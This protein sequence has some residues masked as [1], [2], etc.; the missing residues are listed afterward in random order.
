MVLKFDSSGT[1]VYSTFLGGSANDQ[2][3]PIVV[4]PD[5]TVYVAGYTQSSDFPVTPGAYQTAYGGG[6]DGFLARISADGSQLLYSTYLGGTGDEAVT[7]LLLNTDGSLW[8][9]GVASSAGLTPS[10]NAFQKAPRGV[11][12]SFIAKAQFSPAGVLQLPYLT[13]IGGSQ[14][15]Q[16]NGPGEGWPS[17]LAV[18]AAGNVYYAGTTQSSDFPVTANAYEQPF[19]L[20]H[21]CVNDALPISTGVVTKL[22]PDLS[23]M[24]YSTYFGGKTEDQIGFPY[25]NQGI[26]TIRLDSTGNIWLYGYTAESDLPTTS[27]ALS[28][29]LNTTGNANG[30]DAFLGEL[31]PDGTKLIYGTYIG[32][33]GLDSASSMVFDASGNIWLSGVT[34]STDFPVTANALQAQNSAGVNDLTVTQ[35]SPD[36]TKLLYSTYFGGT[37]DNGFYGASLALDAA[38]NVHLAGLRL[39]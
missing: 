27:N 5:G 39:P 28:S 9:S 17:S 21:G 34:H 12:N 11:D 8:M 6:L 24:L 29:K 2:A 37:T 30:Q 23:Q 15:G 26:S 3:G 35:L 32:G 10:A 22:S 31:S 33:S 14:R 36:G 38:G 20:S 13:F 19:T 7:S 25:C 1:L 16:T 4:N 18:D